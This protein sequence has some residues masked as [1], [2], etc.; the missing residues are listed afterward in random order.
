MGG[1]MNQ[2]IS[3]LGEHQQ[4]LEQQY[5][6]RLNQDIRRAITDMLH[7]KSDTSRYTQWHCGHCQHDQQLP[8]SCGNRNC[9][10][11]LHQTTSNWLAR[12]TNKLLPVHY[13]MVTFTL[14]Y[15]LR[16]LA[17]QHPKALYQLM[18]QVTSTLL[19][20][21]ATRE[22]KGDLGFTSI[23]HTHNRKR[24]LHPHLHILVPSGRYDVAQKQ[25]H[26]GDKAYLFNAFALAKVWRARMIDAINNCDHMIQTNDIPK[27]WVVDCRK[28]GFGLS[29]L[30]YL[31]RYLY[32]GVLPDKDIINVTNER[33]TFQYKEGGTNII[34]TRTLPVLKFLWLILQHVLPK[35]LQRVRDY[36]FLRGNAKKLRLQIQLLLGINIGDKST[37]QNTKRHA[38]CVCPCCQ[39][40]MQFAGIFR[41]SRS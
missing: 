38:V 18:F 30:Q 28:V 20:D 1:F 7:C 35:G 15:Q 31:S 34:K 27:K 13:F 11:C 8:S 9:S 25:W 10:Q 19:K 14:P 41:Q 16:A 37:Q 3:L 29:S 22:N 33:V 4:Q 40:E 26:K 6:A 17:E 2:F 36:G 39:Y 24:D 23:L 32:R 21:F 5:G 12:Q